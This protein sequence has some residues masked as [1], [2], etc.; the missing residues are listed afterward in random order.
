M[1]LEEKRNSAL[2]IA[3]TLFDRN[4]TSGTTANLSFLHDGR[5]FITRSGSCFGTLAAGDF[6]EIGADGLSSAGGGA[7]PSKE[8]PLHAMLY[9]NDPETLSVIHI[10]SPYG[11]LWSCIEHDDPR[12][13]F[14]HITPYLDMKLGP[15][16]EVPYAPP[17]SDALF[18]EFHRCLGREKGYLLK[19]HGPIVGGRTLMHAFECIE[20]LE[21]TAFVCWE[22][23]KA[24]AI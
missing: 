6:V 2:W 3:H 17:G 15:V 4:K 12:D 10:H 8:W 21:Q 18:K 24:G 14:P 23:R 22:L 20:E 1:E 13:V 9:E 7:R 5:I 16:A 19:N 11:V